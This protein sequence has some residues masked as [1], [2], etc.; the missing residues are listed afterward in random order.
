MPIYA[1]KIV[2]IREEFVTR[3]GGERGKRN[4]YEDEQ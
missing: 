1:A 2:N 4:G 3:V